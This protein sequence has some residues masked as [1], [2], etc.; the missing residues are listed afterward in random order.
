LSFTKKLLCVLIFQTVLV[1]GSFYKLLDMAIKQEAVSNLVTQLSE[2]ELIL[3]N[4]LQQLR[5]NLQFSLRLT[6]SDFAFKQA[7]A[8]KDKDT[9]LSIIENYKGRVKAD[10]LIL[11]NTEGKNLVDD[12]PD[13]PSLIAKENLLTAEKNDGL[14]YFAIYQNKVFLFILAPIR[15]PILRGFA[16]IGIE[17]DKNFLIQVSKS[18]NTNLTMLFGND[19]EQFHLSNLQYSSTMPEIKQISMNNIELIKFMAFGGAQ[20]GKE[21]SLFKDKKSNAQ[22][23]ISKSESQMLSS[24]NNILAILWKLLLGFLVLSVFIALFWGK[25]LGRRLARLSQ[26]VSGLDGDHLEFNLEDKSQDEIGVLTRRFEAMAAQLSVYINRNKDALSTIQKQKNKLEQSNIALQRQ[27]EEQKII[28]K[29]VESSMHEQDLGKFVDYAISLLVGMKGIR[30]CSSMLQ[31]EGDQLKIISDRSYSKDEQKSLVNDSVNTTVHRKNIMIAAKCLSEKKP[32]F[33]GNEEIKGLIHFDQSDITL[34]LGSYLCIPLVA[35]NESVG[36]LNFITEH[37]LEYWKDEKNMLF[38][39]L[40]AG[41]ISLAL[42]KLFFKR[43]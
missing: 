18:T 7:F 19:G 29:I 23:L 32:Y 16:Q 9:I 22:M 42:G 40:I 30:Q 38:L 33:C 28:A 14:D 21:F 25:A 1:L 37:P 15:A 35:N 13:R 36:V 2:T 17:I 3:R 41:K 39:Q 5:E 11:L 27:V 26:A 43:T 20:I 12:N 10:T 8:Q 34:K 24:Y 6:V 31:T 4:N